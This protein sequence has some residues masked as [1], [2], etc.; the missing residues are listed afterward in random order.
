MLTTISQAEHE[1]IV[2]SVVEIL[3]QARVR[4]RFY[5]RRVFTYDDLYKLSYDITAAVLVYLDIKI[6]L[7]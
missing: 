4:K 7:E 5:R 2:E 6:K 3:S 1:D